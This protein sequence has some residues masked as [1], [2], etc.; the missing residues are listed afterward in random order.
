MAIQYGT[1]ANITI[2]GAGLLSA[3][4]RASTAVTSGTTNNTTDYLVQVS[5]LAPATTSGNKQVVVYGYMSAD[6]TT[7]TG[8]SATAD[9]ITG[10]DAAAAIGS[11][12]NLFFMGTIQLNTVSVTATEQFSVSNTFGTV[13]PVWGIVLYNDCGTT[14]GATVTAKYREVYYT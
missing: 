1:S 2:T 14:L 5:V 9:N 11:P 3:A 7:Y 12:T 6:G 13:P 8:N 4:A 10:T